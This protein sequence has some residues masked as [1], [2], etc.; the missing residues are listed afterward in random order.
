MNGTY[1]ITYYTTSQGDLV[2]SRAIKLDGR[3]SQKNLIND[4]EKWT[5]DLGDDS[6]KIVKFKGGDFTK[7]LEDCP[8]YKI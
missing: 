7:P 2:L 3:K 5:K 4:A 6:F 8:L 1:L